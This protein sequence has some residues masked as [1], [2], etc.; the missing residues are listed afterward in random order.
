VHV[1]VVEHAAI[2][3]IQELTMGGLVPR[4]PASRRH[5]AHGTTLD[6]DQAV[7]LALADLDRV[8]ANTN[9]R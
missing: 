3:E 7:T 8:I 6:Y 9:D 1:E 2:D 5:T 4:S